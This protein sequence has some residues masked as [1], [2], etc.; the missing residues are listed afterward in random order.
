[1]TDRIN[2]QES[3]D[4]VKIKGFT[5]VEALLSIAIMAILAGLAAPVYFVYVTKNNFGLAIDA[6]VRSLRRAQFLAQ[7]QDRDS[8]WGVYFSNTSIVI[9]AGNNYAGRDNN[10]DEKYDFPSTVTSTVVDINFSKFSGETNPASTT[11]RSDVIFD[12]LGDSDTISVNAKGM[13]DF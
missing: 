11:L 8:N 9:Y 3:G 13:V 1:M 5:L 12:N 2:R 4:R 7:N 10:Y 6:G